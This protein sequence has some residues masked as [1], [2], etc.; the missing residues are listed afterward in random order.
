MEAYI[1]QLIKRKTPGYI[2]ALQMVCMVVAICSVG[3]AMVGYPVLFVGAIVFGVAAFIL[4]GNANT[5]YEYLYV[6]KEFTV[7]RITAQSRRKQM[8]V[9]ALAHMEIMAPE[10]SDRLR[11]YEN[12]QLKVLDFSAG[13]KDSRRFVMIYNVEGSI[14]KVILEG[15]DEL[16]Q[17]FF[18]ASPRNVFKD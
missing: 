18:S 3:G 9:Y 10:N 1:E 12:R 13:D 14:Q 16:Y 4:H 8:A 17:C 15:S 2:P 5:E 7:D 6:D 11:S